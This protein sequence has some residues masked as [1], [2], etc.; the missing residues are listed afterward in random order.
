MTQ[1]NSA[2]ML[3]E[4]LEHQATGGI[5]AIYEEIRRFSGAPYDPSLQRYVT[6]K[7]GALKWA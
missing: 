7:P 4:L 6:T 2:Q 5:V 3:P 1:A